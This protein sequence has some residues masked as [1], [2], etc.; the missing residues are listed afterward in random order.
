MAKTYTGQVQNGVV[1]FD[2]SPPPIP[3]GTKVQITAQ[4][5]D[6]VAEQDAPTLYDRLKPIVGSIQG[7]PEDF[8]EQ[9]DHYI[10]GTPKLG[11]VAEVRND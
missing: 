9:N 10:H 2:A 7:L 6:E 5:S 11:Q 3:A 4:S 8:A 1:V